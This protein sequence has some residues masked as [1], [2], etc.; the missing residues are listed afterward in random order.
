[1]EV[2]VWIAHYFQA[3]IQQLQPVKIGDKW[4]IIAAFQLWHFP[5]SAQ[6]LINLMVLVVIKRV[7]AAP[8]HAVVT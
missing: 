3:G 7:N 8:V 5:Q 6:V 2:Q 1:M 4:H